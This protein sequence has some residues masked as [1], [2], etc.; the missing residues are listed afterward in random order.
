M[1]FDP[2]ARLDPSQVEDRRGR[3]RGGPMLGRA[4]GPIIA[5]GGGIGVVLLIAQL[6][7]G[8]GLGDLGGGVPYLETDPSVGG[9]AGSVQECRTGAD[10]NEREDCRVVG[11]VNS[12]QDF[13]TKEFQ[14]RGREYEPARTVIFSGSTQAACGYASGAQGPFYC[15]TDGKIYLDLSFFE[16]LERDFGATGGPFAVAYV[17]A[18][19][20]GHHVQNVTGLLDQRGSPSQGPQGSG[21]RTELQADCLAGI[22]AHHAATTG[23]LRPPTPA[24]IASALDAAAAVGDDRTQRRTQGRVTPESWTHGSSEQRQQWFDTGYRTGGIENCDTARGPL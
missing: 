2:N 12:I 14:Q 10:A 24:D 11:F 5:G 1:S 23:S 20:Y 15:P 17:I 18:H 22:W 6:L 9:G 19:E 8:G 13:W 16:D 21:V 4:G 7:L 3:G